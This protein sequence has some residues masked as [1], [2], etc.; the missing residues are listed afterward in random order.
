MKH[1]SFDPTARKD[2]KDIIAYIYK[3][4]PTAARLLRDKF[5]KTFRLLAKEPF[6]GERRTEIAVTLR[7]FS[8]GNYVIYFRP[9]REGVEIIRVLHGARDTET[10]FD[11]R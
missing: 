10:L 3:D 6:M 11:E 1:A 9:V 4:N 8:V 7:S 5:N 2:L